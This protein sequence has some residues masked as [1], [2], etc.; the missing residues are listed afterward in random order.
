VLLS[1][2]NLHG[3]D[4]AH[5]TAHSVGFAALGSVQIPHG[6]NAVSIFAQVA[7]APGR[8]DDV[9]VSGTLQRRDTP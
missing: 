1:S 4:F 8:V 5:V 9:Q 3:F 7:D 6:F 2:A